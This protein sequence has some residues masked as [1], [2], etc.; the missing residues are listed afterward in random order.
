MSL[1]R[2]RSASWLVGAGSLAR[3]LCLFMPPALGVGS[4]GRSLIEAVGGS[5]SCRRQAGSRQAG[6]RQASIWIPLFP[7]VPKRDGEGKKGFL[8]GQLNGF[9][10]KPILSH[11]NRHGDDQT[12]TH[13]RAGKIGGH[14]PQCAAFGNVNSTL[15]EMCPSVLASLP[16][17][18]SA[19]SV[20]ARCDSGPEQIP[21]AHKKPS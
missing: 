15:C 13:P 3:S 8:V 16:R 14:C 11:A 17:N 20:P 1:R 18:P 12:R 21:A 7:H 2:Q 9:P 6:S 10:G 4:L 5:L 19:L